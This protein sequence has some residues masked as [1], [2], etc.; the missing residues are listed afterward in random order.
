MAG[1]ALIVSATPAHA[2]KLQAVSARVTATGGPSGP[3]APVSPVARCP[4][5]TK[6]VAGGYETSA[7]QSIDRRIVV[8]ESIMVKGT[9]WRVSGYESSAAP[10]SGKVV[11]YVY[12]GER[13]K[14]LRVG[15]PVRTDF[16]PATGTSTSSG[17]EC[18]P[19]TRALA[20][21][22]S[23]A[24][25][26]DVY[27]FRSRNSGQRFWEAGVT[28][29]GATAGSLYTVEAYCAKA[30]VVQR[31]D[32]RSVAGPTA[33]Q[34]MAITHRCPAGTSPRSGGFDSPEPAGGLLSAAFVYRTRRLGVRW[35]AYAA[36]AGPGGATVTSYAY[37][38][39]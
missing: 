27:F 30:K 34:A 6:A 38:R 29:V 9:A 4:A 3:G 19:H 10:A 2:A 37:C 35:V 7:P 22:F 8:T 31:T 11:A 12:C 13:R 17:A 1:A 14:A 36:A 23:A 26:S 24:P 16:I 20:G 39:A 28:N 5:G 18:P 25:G 15:T 33:S 32:T 21:G